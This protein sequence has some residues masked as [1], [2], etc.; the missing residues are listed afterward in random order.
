MKTQLTVILICACALANANGQDETAKVSPIA[1]QDSSE[2]ALR[3]MQYEI[4]LGTKLNSSVAVCIDRSHSTSWM[5]PENSVTE[6]SAKSIEKIRRTAELCQAARR[7]QS[8]EG[9]SDDLR[10]ASDIRASL[11]FQLKAAQALEVSKRTAENC[12]GQSNTD[13][14]FKACMAISLPSA[15]LDAFWPKWESI[16]SRRI[17]IAADA[18]MRN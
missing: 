2:M 3:V 9:Q 12:I 1:G 17:S 10:L 5:L 7:A 8:T 11:E 6:A 15:T 4:L 16:F 18:P 14:K 13:E